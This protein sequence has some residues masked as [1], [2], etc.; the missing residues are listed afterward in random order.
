MFHIYMLIVLGTG[1]PVDV[2]RSVDGFETRTACQTLLPREMQSYAAALAAAS[3]GGRR[4][5]AGA[6]W[7]DAEAKAKLGDAIRLPGDKP[8]PREL[9]I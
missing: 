4:V 1:Q 6:C 9:A 3:G 8:K 2:A 7:S 5:H